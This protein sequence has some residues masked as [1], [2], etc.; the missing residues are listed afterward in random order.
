MKKYLTNCTAL[1]FSIV[2]LLFGVI[3]LAKA[4][5]NKTYYS[6]LR[7]NHVSLHSDIKG[8]LPISKQQASTQPHYIFTYDEADRLVEIENNFYNNQRLHPL[9]NFGSK[10]VKISYA[11]GQQIREFYDVNRAPMLNIRGVHKEVYLYDDTGFIYQLNFF[12]TENLPAESRWNINEY[13]W[14]KKDDLVI[15]Q[16]FNIKSEKQPLSPYFP[17]NDTAIEYGENNEPIRHYNLDTNFD[18]VENEHGIAYYQDN[19]SE[20]GLHTKYAYY[21]KDRNLTLNQWDFAYGV[22]HYDNQGYYTGRD[23]FGVNGEKL[24]AR[25]P[26]MIKGTVEDDKEI[27]RISKSYIHALRDLNP[28]L[29]KEVLHTSLAKHTVPPFPGPDGKH[30][31]RETTYDQMIGFAKSWNLNGVRFPPTMNINITI[32]DKHR[33]MA[34]VKM[35]S[36]NWVEYLHLVKLNGQWKIKNLLWDYH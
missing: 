9:T 31:L 22:K 7:Y 27:Q 10:Y 33:N 23:V 35:V 11:N 25:Q 29:M 16:R 12:N 30:T 36:D 24:P 19:Y 34:T 4:E 13:R 28:Q 5:D 15:E 14:H 8:I 2:T 3:S 18:I 20:A 6:S 17:F 26:T 21:G 1:T 32:L